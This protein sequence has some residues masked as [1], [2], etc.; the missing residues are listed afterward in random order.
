MSDESLERLAMEEDGPHDDAI[1]AV[2]QLAETGRLDALI[3][4]ALSEKDL[5]HLS[6]SG[7]PSHVRSVRAALDRARRGEVKYLAVRAPNGAPIAKAGIDYTEHRDAGTLFQLTTHARLRSLGIGRRI[8]A[9]A[10]QHIRRRGCPWV[11]LGVEDHN[12]RARALY[13]RLG[14]EF[15][16]RHPASWQSEDALGNVHLY[17]TELNLLRKHLASSVALSI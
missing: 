3:I 11:V 17:E 14:Y 9:E 10:E 1:N 16:R 8:I 12:T 2:L 4:D 7:S 5:G 13:E 15:W 6:W